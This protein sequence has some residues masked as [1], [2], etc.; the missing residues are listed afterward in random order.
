MIKSSEKQG[1]NMISLIFGVAG[2]ALNFLI[3]QQK[4]GKKLLLLKLVSDI[5][6]CIHYYLLGAYAGA[7]VALIGALRETTFINVDKKSKAGP[8]FLGFFC[9]LSVISAVVTWKSIFSLLPS[10]ASVLSVISF[11]IANPG[12]SRIMSF[13]I[14]ACMFSYSLVSG[15]YSGIANEIITVISS[16]AGMIRMR[17]I[18]NQKEKEQ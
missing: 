17:K 9:L 15:S 10:V 16:I 2:I 5:L 8:M 6:W 4:T 1:A 12:I 7:C 14:S 11:Y 18:Q 13:P 3:Y